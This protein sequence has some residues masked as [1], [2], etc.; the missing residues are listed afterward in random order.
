MCE[1]NNLQIESFALIHGLRNKFQS[2]I[3]CVHLFA[4]NVKQDIMDRELVRQEAVY[5]GPL[6]RRG[7]REQEL[8]LRTKEEK[9]KRRR[10]EK[11]GGEGREGKEK[12]KRQERMKSMQI[13][14]SRSCL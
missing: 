4:S 7:G 3:S 10:G 1:K 8:R 11:R 6:K 2:I 5:L 13:F 14:S 12:E 9:G